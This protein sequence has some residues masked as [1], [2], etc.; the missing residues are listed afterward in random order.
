MH[1]RKTLLNNVFQNRWDLLPMKMTGTFFYKE[2]FDYLPHK[3]EGTV[4]PAGN[5]S[6][7]LK[8]VFMA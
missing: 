5:G 8:I 4:D 6:G 1:H 7:G 3:S 2:H